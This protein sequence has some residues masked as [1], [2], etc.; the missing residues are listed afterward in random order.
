MH[1]I[2][3]PLT[4]AVTYSRWLHMFIPAAAASV[5][6]F[7][8]DAF[9]APLLFAVPIG[10]IPAMRL[11]E[12]IQA[13]LLL[14]PSE[15][16]RPDASIAAASSSSWAERWRTVLWL[17]VRL[18]ISAGAILALW[19]PVTSIELVLS[20]AGRPPGGLA[21]G[22]DP[23]WWNVLLAPLPIIPLLVLVVLGGRLSTAA[24]RWLL[25]PSPTDR[26]TVL[27]G[28]TEELL[29]RNRM[30]RELHDSIGHALTVAVVQA[31]AARTAN[32][33]AFTERAL[34]AIEETGRDALED[35]ERVLRVLRESGTP[36]SRRP[37]LAEAERLLDSAR[38]SGAKVDA[39]VSG[40][41]GL[42]PAPVSR[43]GYR[44]LQESLTNV[45]RHAGPVSVRVTITVDD[46]RLE[47]EVAN[48]L[49]GAAG[50][51][52]SGSGLRGIRERAALLGGKARTE[53]REDE[54]RVSVSLPLDGIR[55]SDAVHRSS[56]R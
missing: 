40:D 25:R 21:E 15:S 6:F 20:A 19:L 27:E 17:E 39:R 18:L 49:S 46:G 4:S 14:T 48:P 8:S 10:L 11:E 16:G 3:T 22:L 29:E 34:A 1:R 33:P 24:A 12:G 44:I 26:L 52:G 53:S 2:L 7:I 56:G 30:A 41:L 23:H 13:Q 36:V 43:E 32:D 35:L 51:P 50:L 9:W 31:G 47:L 54:W 5:W 42:V 45:L 38:R 28:L 55:W 37:T